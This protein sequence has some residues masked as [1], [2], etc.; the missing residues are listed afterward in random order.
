M[1]L[2][3]TRAAFAL[4]AGAMACVLALAAGPHGHHHHG[5]EPADNTAGL[6]AAPTVLA[7]SL[8][9][10]VRPA[11]AGRIAWS[12]Q[13][14]L[15][16]QAVP[17]ALRYEVRLMTSEGAPRSA[18]PW[19]DTCWGVEA[20]AGENAADQGMPHRALMLAMQAGQAALQV[21]AVFKDGRRSAWTP[22][23]PV[24]EVPAD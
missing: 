21:R 11:G 12:T 2:R 10:R 8:E 19:S 15:C 17:A 3:R 6:S 4:A 5:A 7:G 22:E 23:Q 18:Q 16:W 24:G 9:D 13:W 14:T 1:T 20:A